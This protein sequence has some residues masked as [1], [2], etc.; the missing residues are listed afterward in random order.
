MA[1]KS[2]QPTRHGFAIFNDGGSAY[3]G[4]PATT[5]A[6]LMTASSD[7][8]VLR[9]LSK[10]KSQSR[11]IPVV[12]VAA[13]L[14]V[15]SPRRE[16]P[17]LETKP[18][19]C[20]AVRFSPRIQR[21]QAHAETFEPLVGV[22]EESSSLM[23]IPDNFAS[24]STAEAA[25]TSRP[26]EEQ[27]ML[28]LNAVSDLSLEE[29]VEK[30]LAGQFEWIM[31]YPT[32]AGSC[33]AGDGIAQPKGESSS[34]IVVYGCNML[35]AR[36]QQRAP[37]TPAELSTDVLTLLAT[38]LTQDSCH[39]PSM[40]GHKDVVSPSQGQVCRL[41]PPPYPG[42]P[43]KVSEMANEVEQAVSSPLIS[44]VRERSDSAASESS[45]ADSYSGS[46][47][48]DSFDELVEVEEVKEE[49]DAVRE[50]IRTRQPVFDKVKS[51]QFSPDDARTE[52]ATAKANK[53]VSN[54]GYSAT[55]RVK[56][57]QEK[58]PSSR[59][60][61]SLT[62]R[63]KKTSK[64]G[65]PPKVLKVEAI[66]CQGHRVNNRL[67]TPKLPVKSSKP[68]TVPKFELPGDA[69]ARRLK[70]QREARLAQQAEAQKAQASPA[71]KPRLNKLLAL[72]TFEL[73]GEAISRRKR[74]EREAKLRAEE[75]EVRRRRQFKARPIRQS[76][77]PAAAPR[78]T[79]TSR[80]RQSKP[81]PQATGDV[82]IRQKR[83][84]VGLVGNN[85]RVSLRNNHSNHIKNNNNNNN[86]SPPTEGQSS[87]TPTTKEC[88]ATSVSAGRGAGQRSSVSFEKLT[89]QR[90]GGREEGAERSG[91]ASREWPAKTRR[92]GLAGRQ[93][94]ENQVDKN[95][96]QA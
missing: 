41:P 21:P 18:I 53:R 87:G 45:G 6:T 91:M 33:A 26:H 71:P 11:A 27:N 17:R 38:T 35:P 58:L 24:P 51:V 70:E 67:S 84:S 64:Q 79:L 65:S 76:T 66:S 25:T 68:T 69:V 29:Q 9:E 72:P 23:G 31:T 80:A 34:T 82:E 46:R 3:K 83:L 32:G 81:L 12:D 77:G 90:Q 20:Q 10:G 93:A 30:H 73:P 86:D 14:P 52:A 7:P 54:A 28:L 16:R 75:E 8:N 36:Q 22:P 5:I 13:S 59:R 85:A 39:F 63:H 74:E 50:V 44:V 19:K 61:A 62:L 96:T 78:E 60:S 42:T 88:R 4:E 40:T 15:K 47:T 48:E 57:C 37:Q 55:V 56:P 1:Q 94:K 43:E 49:V 2:P 92:K 89:V 95:G